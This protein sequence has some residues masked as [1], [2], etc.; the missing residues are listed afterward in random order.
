MAKQVSH[1][2]VSGAI[3]NLVFYAMEGRGYVRRKSSLTGKDFKTKA[4]FKG[5]RQS[6]ARFA[7]GNRIAGAVYRALPVQSKNYHLFCIIKSKA[8]ALLKDGLTHEDTRL[9]LQALV[10]ATKS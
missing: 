4:C 1:T 10:T 3:D 5:S 6:A 9:Q 7:V 2:I 8:I